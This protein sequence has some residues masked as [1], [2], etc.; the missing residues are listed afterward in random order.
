MRAI[1]MGT[2]LDHGSFADPHYATQLD[3]ASFAGPAA[4]DLHS[5]VEHRTPRRWRTI[6]PCPCAAIASY[7]PLARR[8]GAASD[9]AES[10]WRW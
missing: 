5:G 4:R 10:S 1:F 7:D 2:S 6:E 9:Q 3:V 8:P